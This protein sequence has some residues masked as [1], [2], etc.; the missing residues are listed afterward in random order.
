[1]NHQD[2]DQLLNHE[3]DGIKEFD[4]P[5]PNWWLST[6]YG[7]IV[8]AFFYLAYYHFAGG[9]S[10]HDELAAD[11][12]QIYATRKS[13]EAKETGP[14]EE[15]LAAILASQDRIDQGHKIFA[16]KCASCH[17]IHGEGIVGPN[18]TDK[19]WIHGAGTLMDILAVVS[20]G[21]AEKGMPPWKGMMK[22][23]E[24]QSVVAYVKSINGTHPSNA[25][26]PQGEE[27]K[28]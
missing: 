13:L 7:A 1:M 15:S 8:F 22:K 25:K 4:N 3:Y 10:L 14:T 16:E 21:V 28:D 5:L 26:A 11:L 6:F 2:K 23:E 9:P 17:G 24:V 19:Y 18:L 27:A 12:E 20:D